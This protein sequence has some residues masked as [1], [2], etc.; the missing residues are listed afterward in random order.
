MS[1]LTEDWKKMVALAREQAIVGQYEESI[2]HY[3][4][5]INQVETYQNQKT[6]K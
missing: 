1:I 4:I 6:N 2:N 3:M 5:L